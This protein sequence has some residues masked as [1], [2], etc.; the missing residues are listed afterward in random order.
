MLCC[1]HRL[2]KESYNSNGKMSYSNLTPWVDKAF[3]EL[4]TARFAGVESSNPRI[5]EY[6]NHTQL[7][8][9]AINDQTAWCAG[10][11]NFTLET[12]G[13]EG[14]GYA[15]ALSFRGSWGQNLDKPAYGSVATVSYGHGQGHVGIVIG[16]NPNGQVLIL[17][18]NQ[19]AA[20]PGGQNEVNI[21][22]NNQSSFKYHYPKGL[23]PFYD[24]PKLNI[25]GKSIDY[26][27]TR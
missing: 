14:T 11:V 25:S 1:I 22:P 8:G 6:L 10:F 9:S 18:G 26:V 20:V 23:A 24:L 5:E 21:S 7:T 4:G 12:S 3:A 17:G 15:P 2:M 13:I 27:N 19:G 16:V